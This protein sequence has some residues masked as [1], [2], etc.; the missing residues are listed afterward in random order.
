MNKKEF[1]KFLNLETR[2]PTAISLYST[3]D[4]RQQ[5]QTLNHH[6]RKI[7]PKRITLLTSQS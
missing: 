4:R 2:P 5:Q 7:L 1:E 3:Q 6:I